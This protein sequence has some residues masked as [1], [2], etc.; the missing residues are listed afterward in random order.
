M[1]LAIDLW[2]WARDKQSKSWDFQAIDFP[3]FSLACLE[4]KGPVTAELSAELVDTNTVRISGK[5]VARITLQCQSCLDAMELF[6]NEAYEYDVSRATLSKRSCIEVSDTGHIELMSLFEDELLLSLPAFP[7]HQSACN[8][9][10]GKD[11]YSAKT[12]AK[13]PFAALSKLKTH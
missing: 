8:A 5:V 4:L 11:Q 2:Q 10:V 7:R 12:E 6:I 1:K 13:N 9:L 3:R